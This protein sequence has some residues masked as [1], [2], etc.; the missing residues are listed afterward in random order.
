MSKTNAETMTVRLPTQVAKELIKLRDEE[1]LPTI[2]SALQIYIQKMINDRITERFDKM[3][4]NIGRLA[5]LLEKETMAFSK[6]AVLEIFEEENVYGRFF[7]SLSPE[8]RKEAVEEA[9]TGN[10]N[11]KTKWAPKLAKFVDP[12]IVEALKKRDKK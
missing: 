3:E 5:Y 11:W 2:G 8:E 10:P 4:K 9:A 12:I 6:E 7:E 1:N